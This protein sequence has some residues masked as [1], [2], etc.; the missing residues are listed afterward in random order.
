MTSHDTYADLGEAA[1]RWV[2]D[3][4]RWDDGPWIPETVPHEGGPPE[5]RDGMHSGIGGR[6]GGA[7]GGCGATWPCTGPANSSSTPNPTRPTF[8]FPPWRRYRGMLAQPRAVG[9][10][11]RR[12][13]PCF[14]PGGRNLAAL[15]H[16]QAD[17]PVAFE[18]IGSAFDP[19]EDDS[20]GAG[21]GVKPRRS[22]A[23]LIG[24][25]RR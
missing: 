15:S 23:P 21:A 9:E 5:E 11:R 13:L 1:W 7:A 19:C 18:R 3:Q 8:I 4:V 6:A 22:R 20:T 2:L 25:I 10:H 24:P 12:S 17:R 14:T 16:P